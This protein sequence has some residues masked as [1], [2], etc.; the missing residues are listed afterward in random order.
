MADDKELEKNLP[1]EDEGKEEAKEEEKVA[2]E[3]TEKVEEAVAEETD[4]AQA[5]AKEETVKEK[6]QAIGGPKSKKKKNASTFEDEEVAEEEVK[7]VEEEKAEETSGKAL[8][9][10]KIRKQMEKKAEKEASLGVYRI[11][12]YLK[13]EHQWE[14]WLFLVI[15]II[16]LLLG[17]LMLN[18]ALQVRKDFPLIGEY[19]TVFAWILVVLASLGLIY[20]LYPFLKPA[21]PELKKITWLTWPKFLGNAIRTFVFIIVLTL[22]FMLYDVFITELLDL[23]I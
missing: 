13:E 21:F 8:V 18:G 22:L 16:T 3:V 10:A 6:K 5:E 1:L 23:I 12:E 11:G 4:E 14:N 7:P 9:E 15:S 20:A 2:E 19:P 17:C